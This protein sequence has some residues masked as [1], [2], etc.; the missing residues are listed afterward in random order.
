MSVKIKGKFVGDLRCTLE[1]APSSNSINTD[2]PID[3]QGKGETFSPT[4]LM[5]AALGSCM[6]TIIAIRAK[7]KKIEIKR[8][9]FFIEKHMNA[10]PRKISLIQVTIE[11]NK[12]IAEIDREYLEQEARKCPVALSLNK[13]LTQE[14]TF[15]YT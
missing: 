3:N 10:A 1:H 15:K 9:T 14:V 8:P 7:T 11:L 4:D 12:E 5:A 13:D 2:A 6:L